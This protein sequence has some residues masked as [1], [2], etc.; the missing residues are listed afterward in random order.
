MT[1]LQQDIMRLLRT[2]NALTVPE[3][4]SS[5][6]HPCQAVQEALHGLD[7][8]GQVFMRNGF[9]RASE[10]ARRDPENLCPYGANNHE[11]K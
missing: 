7:D 5:V 8:A 11:V 1:P 9:Y 6:T 2:T 3:I 4:S 10:F